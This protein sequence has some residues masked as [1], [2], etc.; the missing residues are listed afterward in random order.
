MHKA[1]SFQDNINMFLMLKERMHTDNLS[2]VLALLSCLPRP[3]TIVKITKQ[4]HTKL[5]KFC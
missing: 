2:S 4:P 1:I 3:T 5:I